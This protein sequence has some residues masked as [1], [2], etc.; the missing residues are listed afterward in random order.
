MGRRLPGYFPTK[1]KRSSSGVYP[2]LKRR[3]TLSTD[4]I[5]SESWFEK[6]PPEIFFELLEW[7]PPRELC[8]V[9]IC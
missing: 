8:K 9:R 1:M 2:Q 6:F 3:L 4:L 5:D 7:I